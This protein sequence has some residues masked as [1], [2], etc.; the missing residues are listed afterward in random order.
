MEQND[1]SQLT[2]KAWD[3]AYEDY[4]RAQRH[5]VP[6]PITFDQAKAQFDMIARV[7][8]FAVVGRYANYVRTQE[9]QAALRQ[10]P[11]PP[12]LAKWIDSKLGE[13]DKSMGHPGT[14]H[15][16]SIVNGLLSQMRK[17]ESH[18]LGDD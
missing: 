12:G 16:Q 10:P 18:F 1:Y 8:L 6:V 5:H 3:D 15:Y 7:A 11:C 13:I 14:R 9:G 17:I 2:Q 4:K